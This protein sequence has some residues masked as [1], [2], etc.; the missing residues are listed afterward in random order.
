MIA[1]WSMGW[2]EIILI[3]VLA[4]LVLGPEKTPVYAKKLGEALGM[5]KQYSGKLA[6]E[7]KENVAEPM[8]EV[9]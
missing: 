1:C 5:F 4:I 2:G 8:Q 9:S 3:I 6:T 7:I